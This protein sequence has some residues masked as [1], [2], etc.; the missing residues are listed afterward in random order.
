MYIPVAHKLKMSSE[1][2]IIEHPIGV[3]TDRKYLPLFNE[4]MPI[5]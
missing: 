1:T 4:M 2:G 5:K 3:P